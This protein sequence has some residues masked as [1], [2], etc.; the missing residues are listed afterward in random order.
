M[1]RVVPSLDKV[2]DIRSVLRR[3]PR[4]D[5]K[6]HDDK[7]HDDKVIDLRAYTGRNIIRFPEPPDPPPP[8]DPPGDPGDVR[9]DV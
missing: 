2:R 6:T 9:A 8:P 3:R 7:T 1:L 4:H 5:D